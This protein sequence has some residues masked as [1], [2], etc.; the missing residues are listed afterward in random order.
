MKLKITMEVGSPVELQP[1]VF[2]THLTHPLL[3]GDC[4]FIHGINREEHLKKLGGD[5]MDKVREVFD[6]LGVLNEKTTKKSK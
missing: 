5:T 6:L 2:R 1:G 3:E 4:S